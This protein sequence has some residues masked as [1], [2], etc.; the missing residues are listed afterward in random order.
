MKNRSCS[1]LTDSST[2]QI[3]NWSRK[4]PEAARLGTEAVASVF[5]RYTVNVV[6]F[7]ARDFE[8]LHHVRG[9]FAVCIALREALLLSPLRGVPG[10][11]R[12]WKSF[13]KVDDHNSK[14]FVS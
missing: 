10:I 3:T 9:D 13:V 6:C 8:N 4:T 7:R 2:T 14:R 1:L 12:I 5:C 11:L